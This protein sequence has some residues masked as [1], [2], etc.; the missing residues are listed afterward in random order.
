MLQL[1]GFFADGL[2]E[3]AQQEATIPAPVEALARKRFEARQARDWGLADQLRQEIL[4]KGFIVEDRPDGYR[5]KP[6]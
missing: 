3:S 4:G 2:P 6:K 5:L 1:L